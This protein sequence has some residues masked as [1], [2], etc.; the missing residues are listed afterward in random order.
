M[1]YLRFLENYDNYYFFFFFKRTISLIL[2]FNN[3]LKKYFDFNIAYFINNLTELASLSFLKKYLFDVYFDYILKKNMEIEKNFSF[4]SF[5]YQKKK[6]YT[7]KKIEKIEKIQK[8]QKIHKKVK[9]SY[10]EN[11]LIMMIKRYCAKKN[12]YIHLKNLFSINMNVLKN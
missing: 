4:I 11:Y 2:S 9:N 3:I 1:L 8:I 6:M 10:S 7:I 12:L 5:F